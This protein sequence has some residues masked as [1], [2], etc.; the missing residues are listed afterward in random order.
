MKVLN[1]V[2]CDVPYQ[3]DKLQTKQTKMTKRNISAFSKIQETTSKQLS[4]NIFAEV[5]QPV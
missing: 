1:K 5:D 3:T 4:A 2:M